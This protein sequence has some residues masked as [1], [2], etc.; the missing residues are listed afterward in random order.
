MKLSLEVKTALLVISGIILFIFG[1]N[2]LKGENLLEV[3]DKYYT[4]FDFNGLKPSEPV[5]IMGNPIGRIVNVAYDFESGKTKVSF[6]VDNKLVFSNKSKVRLYQQGLMG[7][8]AL[9]IIPSEI[10]EQAKPGDFLESEVEKDLIQSLSS[11]F[12]GLSSGL[13]VT[14][15]SADSLL[16]GLNSLVKD[17]SEKGIKNVIAELNA[18]L[19]GYKNLSY[20]INGLV[21]KNDESLTTILTNFKTTSES[22]ATLT[23]DLEKANLKE[24]IAKLDSA[25]TKVNGLMAGLENGDGS[26]GKLLKDDKL[27][28]NL[29]G[30]SKQ[31]EQLLQDLK[32]NP[33]R[34]V[35]I[36]VFGRKAKVY[37]AEGNEIKDKK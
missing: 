23:K 35:N 25:L 12:S 7:G 30:A 27:Y 2:Y 1:Y 37:D 36:S 33:K 16:I 34:Y 22:L 24:T 19:K 8:N 10:G 3:S 17:D 6:T 29:E 5:T 9:A 18:T 15:K 13:D 11:N 4:S 21:K 32:L 31:M 14:L 20:N 26:M 28:N